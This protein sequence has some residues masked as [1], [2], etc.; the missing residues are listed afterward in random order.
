MCVEISFIIDDFGRIYHAASL[1]S[2]YDIR[3][4]WGIPVEWSEAEWTDDYAGVT[5]HV[6]S[7]SEDHALA[8]RRLILE[9]FPTREDLV[10]WLLTQTTRRADGTETSFVRYRGRIMSVEEASKQ[11]GIDGRMRRNDIRYH[12]WPRFRT[13]RERV[14]LRRKLAACKGWSMRKLAAENLA[15][16]LGERLRKAPWGPQPDGTFV[17]RRADHI[18]SSYHTSYLHLPG[19]GGVIAWAKD[20]RDAVIVSEAEARRARKEL[21]AERTREQAEYISCLDKAAA[22]LVGGMALEYWPGQRGGWF[23]WRQQGE[24]IT[25]SSIGVLRRVRGIVPP[26]LPDEEGPYRLYDLGPSTLLDYV[27]R[28][29]VASRRAAEEY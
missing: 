20:F 27:V 12:W 29:D 8:L 7:R 16:E 25:L 23:V 19:R 28:G 9:R 17:T 15:E 26:E 4:A 24:K 2:H 6:R 11:K 3:Q 22:W 5:L 10:A 13:M 1:D 14:Y 18:G 21:R